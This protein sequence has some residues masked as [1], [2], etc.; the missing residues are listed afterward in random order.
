MCNRG[1]GWTPLMMM[2]ASMVSHSRWIAYTMVS[3]VMAYLGGCDSDELSLI[4]KQGRRVWV[5]ERKLFGGSKS[6]S[7]HFQV[8][9]STSSSPRFGSTLSFKPIRAHKPRAFVS[10]APALPNWTVPLIPSSR[11]V[12]QRQRSDLQ[13]PAMPPKK[14]A[15]EPAP[16]TAATTQAGTST[17]GSVPLT[18]KTGKTSAPST[19]NAAN[20]DKVLLNIY[21]HY[22]T[23]TP[24]RTKLLDVFL[25]FL[26]AVGALQFLY[27][28]LAGNYVR[29]RT[30]KRSS[31]SRLTFSS[32]SM[33]S[34]R[35]SVELLVNLF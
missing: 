13:P 20:W 15:R 17:A 7:A 24:Q 23:Q 30:H 28:I 5:G 19:I 22:M 34:C 10:Q 18:P 25:G 11:Y 12:L 21:D 3:N 4:E 31:D 2:S 6:A 1:T 26:A 35:A 9:P 14:N 29:A 33:P 16:S 27:C 32:H 8:T